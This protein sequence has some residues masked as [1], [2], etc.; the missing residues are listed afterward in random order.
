[1][2]FRGERLRKQLFYFS[3]DLASASRF[4]PLELSQLLKLCLHKKKASS[5]L[6]S[7]SMQGVTRFVFDQREA[8]P[9]HVCGWIRQWLISKTGFNHCIHE[10]SLYFSL[11]WIRS[12][13]SFKYLNII[14]S[15]CALCF[16]SALAKTGFN[17]RSIVLI[18]AVSVC[19]F[20]GMFLFSSQIKY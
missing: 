4:V 14:L 17:A 2:D 15:L 20:M 8:M 7:I 12:D 10:L 1:M 19:Q 13:M 11:F 3:E 6:I 5:G 9:L 18:V 16:N